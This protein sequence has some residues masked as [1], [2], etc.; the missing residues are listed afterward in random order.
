MLEKIRKENA[1]MAILINESKYKS[2]RVI[3]VKKN[4][5]KYILVR[6]EEELREL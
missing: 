1:E 5:I 4:I 3:D 2:I 6:D